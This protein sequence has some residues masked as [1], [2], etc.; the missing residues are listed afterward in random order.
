MRESTWSIRF[1]SPNSTGY[2][3]FT[4]AH[5]DQGAAALAG[6]FVELARA[7]LHPGAT[8]VK[9]IGDEVMV[10]AS[11]TDAAVQTVFALSARLDAEP[12]FPG[13][14]AGL[15]AGPAVEKNGDDFGTAVNLAA[16]IAGWARS[17]QVYCSAAVAA[18]LPTASRF[19]ARPVGEHR[20]KNLS[21][22]IALF[23][24]LDQARGAAPELELDPVCRMRLDPQSAP[25]RLPYH[26]RIYHFCSL[27]CA[28]A[29]LQ[30]PGSYGAD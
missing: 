25:A 26:E 15:H 5:G 22:P 23:E 21:A 27:E 17:G 16:R 3:A 8:L 18:V 24:L 9:E 13:L 6:R 20:L 7:S 1:C 11:S 12:L 29:F 28:S 2:T 10:V 4:E 14:R 19:S 30:S